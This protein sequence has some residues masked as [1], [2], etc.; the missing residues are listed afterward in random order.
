MDTSPLGYASAAPISGAES[1]MSTPKTPSK[2]AAVDGDAD[3]SDQILSSAS[4]KKK[5]K[6]TSSI[7]DEEVEGEA[8]DQTPTKKARKH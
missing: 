6:K 3:G 2:S 8:S 7:E 4:E 1:T 5:R